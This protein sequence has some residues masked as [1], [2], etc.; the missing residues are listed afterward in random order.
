MLKCIVT[1][2][3]D[4]ICPKHYVNFIC[5]GFIQATV[6]QSHQSAEVTTEVTFTCNAS[7]YKSENFTYQWRLDQTD[8]NGATSGNY[9]ISSVSE[10]DQGMYDCVVTNHWSEMKVSAPIQLNITSMSTT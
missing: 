1:A 10:S 8:I 3:I 6:E 7:G 2:C 4:F 9:T 5:I